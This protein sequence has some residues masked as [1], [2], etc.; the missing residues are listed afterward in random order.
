M[1]NLTSSHFPPACNSK[2]GKR[3]GIDYGGPEALIEAEEEIQ[4]LDLPYNF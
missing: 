4:R 2:I 1:I 3:F